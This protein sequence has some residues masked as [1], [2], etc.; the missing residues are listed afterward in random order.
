MTDIRGE[1]S[2]PLSWMPFKMRSAAS[3]GGD[4]EGTLSRLWASYGQVI[5]W[6]VVAFAVLAGIIYT[7]TSTD[8]VR[9]A[10]APRQPAVA[11]DSFGDSSTRREPAIDAG[12][13]AELADEAAPVEERTVAPPPPAPSA[14]AERE[15][16]SDWIQP[17][18]RRQISQ[19]YPERALEKGIQG[20]VLLRCTFRD[21]V[22][23]DCT[24]VRERP[25]DWRFGSAARRLSRRFRATE[26]AVKGRPFDVTVRFRLERR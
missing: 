24:V 20:R 13:A 23:P 25:D 11:E 2:G 1:R 5:V 22:Y 3:G 19:Y 14:S 26:Q 12:D 15:D 21:R 9:N 18:S 17:L 16:V 6:S 4:S 8:F 10:F 7:V